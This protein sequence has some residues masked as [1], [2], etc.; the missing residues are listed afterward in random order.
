VVG[1][2]RALDDDNSPLVQFATDLRKLRQ[3]AGGPPYRELSRRAHYSAAALSDAAGGRKLP[4][5]AVTLAYVAA[6]DGDTDTWERR[7]RSLAADL[8][9]AEA[10]GTPGERDVQTAPYVG[11][12]AF[13]AADAGKFFGRERLVEQLCTRVAERRFVMVVG[14]SGSGKSSL[15][16]AGLLHRVQTDGLPGIT[17]VALVV[18]SPGSHPLDEC[19][20]RLAALTRTTAASLHPMLRDGPGGLHLTA[21]QAVVDRPAGAEV[22]VVVDQFEEVFTLCSDP[23]ER[24]Q[25]IA[26]LIAATRASNS[27]TR[28][29]LA[30][31]AD[32][33]AHCAHHQ[34][35]LDALRDAQVLVGPMNNAELHSA[36]TQPALD[37][38]YRVEN[39][40]VAE[41]IADAAGQPGVLPLVSHALLE[42]WRRRRGT[43]LTRA[44]YHAVGGLDQAIARAA[45]AVYTSLSASEQRWA[46]QLFVRL[47]ALGDGT[48]DTRRRLDRAELD[49]EDPEAT[50]VLER[51]A[52]A[53]LVLLDRHSVQITHEALVRCWPR[54]HGWLTDDRAGLRIHRQL[55][56][57]ADVWQ[58]LD[59]DPEAVYRGSRLSQADQWAAAGGEDAMNA[60][61]RDFLRASLAEQARETTAARRR[62][63]RLRQ[64]L[65]LLTV[66]LLLTTGATAY[67]LR[68]RQVSVD[69]RDLAIT[70]KV[71]SQAAAL[72]ATNPALAMELRLAAYRLAPVPEARASLLNMFT[73]PYAALLTGHVGAVNALAFSPDGR[74][75]AVGDDRTLRL[76][77][78]ADPTRPRALATLTQLTGPF[79]SVA[80]SPD[81][82]TVAA[83]GRDGA[84]RER[85]GVWDVTDAAQP[86]VR[87]S[88]AGARGHTSGSV[89]FSPDGRVLATGGSDEKGNGVVRRWDLADPGRPGELPALAVGGGTVYDVAF[90]PS[91]RTLAVAAPA[92]AGNLTGRH[93]VHLWDLG[94]PGRPREVA[95]IATAPGFVQELAFSPDG[96]SLV[97]GHGDDT[98]TLWDLS[99]PTRPAQRDP[100]TA[101]TAAVYEAVYSPDGHT[102]A[103]GGTDREIRLWDVTDPRHARLVTTLSGATAPASA[104]AFRPDGRTLAVAHGDGVVRLEDIAEYTFAA[105]AGGGA[106]AVD[107]SADGRTLVSGH[108]NGTIGVADATDPYRRVLFSAGTGGLPVIAVSLGPDGHTL[109]TTGGD[110]AVTLWNVDG[111]RTAVVATATGPLV[112]LTP[113]L[114]FAPD[115]RTL[116]ASGR[117]NSV[118]LW[119]VSDPRH[120]RSLSTIR[121]LAAAVNSVAFSPD[122]RLL[123]TA[124]D[125]A[126]SGLWDIGDPRHPR[127]VSTLAGPAVGPA[128]SVAFG[129][130]GRTIALANPGRAVGLWDVSD[131]SRPRLLSTVV[132]SSTV[133]SVVF[134][135]DGRRLAAGTTDGTT[136]VWDV[137]DPGHPEAFVDLISSGPV[138]SVAFGP[139]NRVLATAGVDWR[140]VNG[141][142]RVWE[143]DP[144][145]A[146]TRVCRLAWPSIT[147]T[148]WEQY[149][150][151]LAYRPP[152]SQ[153]RPGA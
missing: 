35:L 152:C 42:T 103:T 11:L 43:T 2:E 120:P 71:L 48:E 131:A 91:G 126:G 39:A 142:P 128:L 101:A 17:D 4:S 78:S 65:A 66:L 30:L 55:T 31:R 60:R 32:F 96:R 85:V 130:G 10:A 76:W 6:C 138:Y 5:L 82:H 57:A 68:A 98:V 74:T 116:A 18:M 81:G 67:A 148:E 37:A 125:G 92:A 134:S 73:T 86:R 90:G 132:T 110:G 118:R 33:Y 93:K 34:E 59:R 53:R 105:R 88:V 51:L 140:G 94:D 9:T 137:S 119:D 21:L 1:T 3:K 54:L 147:R 20:A 121:G 87:V 22:L 14:P 117:D 106:E 19:A 27:R 47:V 23:Q 99:D 123:A 107:F 79:D 108:A 149:F 127:R 129:P 26:L 89:A 113:A 38:G 7:W 102:L 70:Q 124:G 109:A 13:Q 133:Y 61:E 84:G 8:A 112:P 115:G 143:L 40:L 80:F 64:L 12:A 56:D 135:P 36:I 104:I 24:T 49:P 75:L 153:L 52:A 16:Q 150:P 72:R 122:G 95:A 41:L 151:G 111:R 145:R 83:L 29:V 77:D 100:L 46:R 50:A 58:R 114:A 69:Q 136:S 97:T 25:F 62:T 15:L 45:E 146:A 44:G 28:V 63:T 139:D 141:S 144:E